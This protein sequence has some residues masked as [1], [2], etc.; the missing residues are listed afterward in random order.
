MC[1]GCRKGTELKDLCPTPDD[2]RRLRFR[3]ALAIRR[4]QKAVERKSTTV[5]W[6]QTENHMTKAMR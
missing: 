6:S 3:V 1:K 5:S 4:G 2:L